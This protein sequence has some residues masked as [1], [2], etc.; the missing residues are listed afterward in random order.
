MDATTMGKAVELAE[1][2]ARASEQGENERVLDSVCGEE[3][4]GR[5]PKPLSFSLRMVLGDFSQRCERETGEQPTD[6]EYA[7]VA[8]FALFGPPVSEL[9]KLARDC[10]SFVDAAFAFADSVPESD[11]GK[12]M[13]HAVNK[14]AAYGKAAGTSEGAD[15]EPEKNG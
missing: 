13:A 15:G 11:Y 9:R 12:M 10:D 14:V 4:A 5:D 3:V 8:T 2:E 6:M 7:S 1:A